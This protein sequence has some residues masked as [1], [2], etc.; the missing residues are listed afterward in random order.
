M[1]QEEIDIFFKKVV[2]SLDEVSPD[3]DF[4]KEIFWEKLQENLKP[5]QQK[6]NWFI[7][8]AAAVLLTVFTA[9]GFWGSDKKTKPTTI[10]TNK[11]LQKKITQLPSAKPEITETIPAKEMPQPV[12]SKTETMSRMVFKPD[13]N[14]IE[15]NIDSE[16]IQL[17][18][19]YK[20]P[21]SFPQKQKPVIQKLV[22]SAKI[23]KSKPRFPL[24]SANQ[25]SSQP[26][27]ISQPTE[28]LVKINLSIFQNSENNSSDF[29]EYEKM[30]KPHIKPKN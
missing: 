6:P 27:D 21:D 9:V 1:E 13:S 16:K 29:E 23:K 2:K 22:S 4:D 7:W 26:R 5:K 15:K 25:L 24:V 18:E 11:P 19:F 12:L 3:D 10:V 30:P 14:S 20:N 8:Q 17:A 28:S